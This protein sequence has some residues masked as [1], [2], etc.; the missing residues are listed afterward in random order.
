MLG[1]GHSE[2]LSL[3]FV[4]TKMLVTKCKI[5]AEDITAEDHECLDGLLK[6]HLL[7]RH[8][9]A[10]TQEVHRYIVSGELRGFYTMFIDTSEIIC[11][12]D[13]CSISIFCG[14]DFLINH[15]KYHHGLYNP[16]NHPLYERI[17]FSGQRYQPTCWE[18]ANITEHRSSLN[19][20]WRYC[21]VITHFVLCNFCGE[22]LWPTFTPRRFHKRFIVLH[23]IIIHRERVEEMLK[24]IWESVEDTDL[25]QHIAFDLHNLQTE[26]TY[27]E[28]KFCPFKATDYLKNHALSHLPI[29]RDII[30]ESKTEK[31]QCELL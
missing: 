20:I 3:Y 21:T 18:K 26:C 14:Y 27:C 13:S 11:E 30:Q 31:D 24:E 29:S 17:V 2:F 16:E 5:C 6:V 19:L 4:P 25:S 1:Y 8:R 9:P 7:D 23:M 15:L 12:F 22:Q 28:R 10:V